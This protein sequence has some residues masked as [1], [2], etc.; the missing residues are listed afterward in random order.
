M[1]EIQKEHKKSF[2]VTD[3][4][5]RNQGFNTEMDHS[6]E[7]LDYYRVERWCQDQ[8]RNGSDFLFEPRLFQST[9]KEASKDFDFPLESLHSLFRNTYVKHIKTNSRRVQNNLQTVLIEQYLGGKSIKD[10]AKES[11]FSPAILARRVV[12]EMTILGKKKLSAAMKN[13]ME[14]LGNI[15]VI[16]PKYQHS[17]NYVQDKR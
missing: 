1:R 6:G 14:E 4:P 2:V 5:P 12:E 3:Y 13:P 15:D 17:E 7:E 10:L 9:M 11:N 8:I 16:K